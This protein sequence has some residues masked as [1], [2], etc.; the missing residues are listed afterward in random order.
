M[1]LDEERILNVDTPEELLAGIVDA[2]ASMK[3]P[4][5]QLRQ[6]RCG[7]RSRVAKFVEVDGGTFLPFIFNCN[8]SFISV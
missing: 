1:G 7:V 4:E 5:D 8:K 3:T 6:T 2:A